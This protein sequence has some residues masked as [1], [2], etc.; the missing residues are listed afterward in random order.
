M[1]GLVNAVDVEFEYANDAIPR[2]FAPTPM[3]I[4][5]RVNPDKV[6]LDAPEPPRPPG[7]GPDDMAWN[8]AVVVKVLDPN[9]SSSSGDQWWG[10][11][12]W[13][14]LREDEF[15]WDG[16]LI[17]HVNYHTSVP[18][19]WC[20][21]KSSDVFMSY[22]VVVKDRLLTD[23]ECPS[24]EEESKMIQRS[25]YNPGHVPKTTFAFR[26]PDEDV[27]CADGG[28]TELH[29]NDVGQPKKQGYDQRI[30]EPHN[31]AYSF[32]VAEGADK[33]EVYL[34]DG[35]TP[36]ED[37]ES[38]EPKWYDGGA[39]GHA[40]MPSKLIIEAKEI[41]SATWGDVKL[42]FRPHRI[43]GA[44]VV[45]S[46]A[47]TMIPMT[48][49]EFDLDT[50]TNNDGI[51]EAD[52]ENEDLF[53][54]IPPGRIVRATLAGNDTPGDELAEI[55]LK[56]EPPLCSGTVELSAVFGG[57][58]ICVWE[59]DGE[60]MPVPLPATWDVSAAAVPPILYV[61]AIDDAQPG[62][63]KLKLAYSDAEGHLI[64]EDEVCLYV[65]KTVSKSPGGS[66]LVSMWSPFR[67]WEISDIAEEEIVDQ[68]EYYGWDV[69]TNIFYD[70][71]GPDTCFGSCIRGNFSEMPQG[72]FVYVNS[73]GGYNGIIAVVASTQEAAEAWAGGDP[74]I[75]VYRAGDEGW[76]WVSVSTD[77]LRTNWQ[78]ETKSHGSIVWIDTCRS[79]T[80]P[81]G[82]G[83][84]SAESV[85]G[86]CAFGYDAC[87]SPFES[88]GDLER[89]LGRMRGSACRSAGE[90]FVAGGHTPSLR[91]FGNGWTTLCPGAVARF[92]DVAHVSKSWGAAIFDTYIGEF[93]ASV[94][95]TAY[96]HIPTSD[97]W[98]FRWITGAEGRYAVGF[99]YQGSHI[100]MTAHAEFCKNQTPDGSEGR[101]LDGDPGDAENGEDLEWFIYEP[102]P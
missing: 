43:D 2:H 1:N 31:Y 73:H 8:R 96:P 10:C 11:Y 75:E 42:C 16:R 40:E 101:D 6:I 68:L 22:D 25:P 54:M 15:Q 90:A 94:T 84:T 66:S 63:V 92:P 88:R 7:I 74:G 5:I 87:S 48:V 30:P 45:E 76:W 20:Y 34:A 13:T 29:L 33:I 58:D 98:G 102:Q 70:D 55:R 86:R 12:L 80:V 17:K 82:G 59:D 85:G 44:A 14:D 100:T 56:I 26:G 38:E 79:G 72:G 78:P 51:I 91:I 95:L 19:E 77:W 89:I 67:D 18:D 62:G 61:D 24:Y 93:P 4:T 53:E 97:A 52:N 32:W 60:T 23:G 41:P 3:P 47:V 69:V 9:M 46:Y 49:L 57:D 36:L 71:T 65:T 99:D 81:P 50:D 37:P 21:T 28:S 27:I 83:E 39:G 35:E 64:S